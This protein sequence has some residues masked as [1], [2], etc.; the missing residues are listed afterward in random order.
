MQLV[1]GLRVA[2]ASGALLALVFAPGTNAA[3]EEE[4]E[5][6]RFRPKFAQEFA[7]GGISRVG[8]RDPG[9]I[10]GGNGGT[11]TSVNYDD[12][13]LNYGRGL[14]SLAVQGRTSISGESQRLEASLEAVYFYDFL[15]AGGD[16]DFRDLSDAARDRAGRDV[17]LNNAFI[18]WKRAFDDARLNVRAGNQRLR[19]SDSAWFGQSIAPVNPVSASRRYQPGNTAK[20]LVVA[21]PMLSAQLVTD[22][23]WTFS[24]FYQFGFKPTEPE[25]SGTLLS[26]NDYYSPGARFLQLG[27]G[28]PLVP[29]E[30]ASV[31][32]PATPFGS[33]VP[34][35]EDRLPRWSDQFGMRAETP[36]FGA[37]KMTI[38]GY[39]MRVHSREPIVSIHTGTLGG[40]LGVTAQD[41]TSSGSYFLEYPEDVSVFGGSAQLKPGAAT[42]LNLNYSMRIRQPLQIDD[43]ILVT[44]GLAPAA[45]VAACSANPA[46]ALCAGTL[47]TLN[48]NPLVAARGGITAA[49]A[50]TFFDTELSGF[51][52][53]NVSQWAIGAIQGLPPVLGAANWYAAAEA[54]GVYIHGFR[55]GFLDASV[56]VRPEENGARRNG[57]ASRSAWGYRLFTRIEFADVAGLRS[58]APSLTWIHDPRG[59]A[60]ITLGTLLEGNKSYIVAFEADI[61]KA[62]SARIAYRAW[63][64]RG[65]DADRFTDRDYISFSLTQKF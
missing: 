65:N 52:R 49:N 18:G 50:G 44:A 14:A 23:N 54:G 61:K 8:G 30:D 55:P 2:V 46:S 45:A 5:D 33:R 58:V 63:L 9:L 29:D 40:L 31:T 17:Y 20:D 62:T 53:F 57:F 43:D 16:T 36:E 25:A 26:A 15:N 28:S 12:G 10:G 27:Q 64:G 1:N 41:Y 19:W 48:R 24:G 4:N 51:E 22:G 35:S 34:R 47:A 7:V 42:Q 39:A 3:G 38:A 56:S 13:N 37:A 6:G 32:T 60:P 11:G 21:V 59:N